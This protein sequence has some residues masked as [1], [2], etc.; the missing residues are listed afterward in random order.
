VVV[1]AAGNY[2]PT[3]DEVIAILMDLTNYPAN[4][5][6]VTVDQDQVMNPQRIPFL[7]AKRTDEIGL[8][9]L[10]PDLVYRDPWGNPY[11]ISLDLNYDDKVRD[12]F[13]RIRIVSQQNGPTGY[14]GLVNT[15][16]DPNTPFFEL[17]GGI[18]VWSAGA[19]RRIQTTNNAIGGFNED[20]VLSWK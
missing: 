12:A 13:Y 7:N 3:N 4:P 15:T 11:L 20:N 9:G 1:K 17:P 18:M 14:N 19:D 2:W 16:S 10:G 5:T 8:P 6:V